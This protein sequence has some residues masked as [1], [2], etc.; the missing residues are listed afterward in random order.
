MVNSKLLSY[1]KI[2]VDTGSCTV[3]YDGKFVD[4]RPQEYRLLILFLQYPNHVLTYDV[5]IYNLYT[6]VNLPTESTIRSHLK[7]LRMAFKKVSADS[8]IIET[9][10]AMGYRLKHSKVNSHPKNTIIAPSFSLLEKFIKLQSIEYLVIEKDLMI[11]SIS[12]GLSIYSDYPEYLKIGSSAE[13]AFPEFIGF[14]EVFEKIR[15]QEKPYFEIKTIARAC[16][17]LRPDYI[18][19]YAI[20]DVGLTITE[21]EGENLLFIFFEDDSESGFY[22]QRLVQQQN[23]GYFMLS[24]TS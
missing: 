5:I 18:N 6:E 17:P 10:Y 22:R 2:L 7:S 23:E 9:V 15:N 14:E 24:K 13:R 11:K 8:E 3:I 21:Q 19:F 4:L 1:D 16:N 20:A 12:P